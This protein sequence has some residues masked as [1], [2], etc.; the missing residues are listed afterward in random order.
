MRGS[1]YNPLTPTVL[2]WMREP[3]KAKSASA[4]NNL[5]HLPTVIPNCYDRA[6][7]PA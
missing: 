2:N 4:R 5:G 1:F 3:M 7:P 6:I